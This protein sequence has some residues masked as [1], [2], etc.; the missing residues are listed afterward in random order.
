ME[1]NFRATNV[2][3]RGFITRLGNDDASMWSDNWI[4]MTI[5]CNKLDY[6]HISVT[7]LY[8]KDIWYDGACICKI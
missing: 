7:T 3:K 8:V 5:L 2:L 6:V 4:S 1:S